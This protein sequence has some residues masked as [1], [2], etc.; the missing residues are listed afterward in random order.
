MKRLFYIFLATVALMSCS[1]DAELN[2]S[3]NDL[4]EAVEFSL[5][6]LSKATAKTEWLEGDAIA[7][8]AESATDGSFTRYKY[9]VGED[10]S[11]SFEQTTLGESSIKN[12]GSSSH[13]YAF[14]PYQAQDITYYTTTMPVWNAFDGDDFMK[15]D[16]AAT[17]KNIEFNFSH[18]FA[19]LTF[20]ITSDVTLSSSD[21]ELSLPG[22]SG[23]ELPLSFTENVYTGS[24]FVAAN[25]SLTVDSYLTMKTEFGNYTLY[26][27][28]AYSSWEAGNNYVYDTT[29]KTSDSL[30]D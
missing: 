10:G 17:G 1:K 12:D 22:E 18:I 2:S 27:N 8:Y 20:N 13:Y 3:G 7:I 26:L 11:L 4:G 28:K 6:T 19:M 30:A 21:V 5:A 14:Y 16:A 15:A 29:L 9:V 24:A 25:A 23:Y